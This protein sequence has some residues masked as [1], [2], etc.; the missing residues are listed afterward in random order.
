MEAISTTVPCSFRPGLRRQFERFA[1]YG[2]PRA[3]GDFITLGQSDKWLKQ[4]GIIDHWNVTTTD[5]ATFFKKTS[6]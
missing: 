2:E 4:A 3:S 1:K 6:K 5:T